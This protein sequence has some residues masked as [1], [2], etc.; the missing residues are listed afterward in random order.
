MTPPTICIN[1]KHCNPIN[2]RWH[3]TVDGHTHECLSPK[4][5]RERLNWVTGETISVNH[6]CDVINAHGDCPHFE[7]KEKA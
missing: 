3:S 5:S 6:W 4:L 1:C 2:A 7:A